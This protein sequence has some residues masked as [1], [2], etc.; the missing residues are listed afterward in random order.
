MTAPERIWKCASCGLQMPGT[1]QCV[2]DVAVSWEP[3][4]CCVLKNELRLETETENI[5]RDMAEGRFPGRS[6]P[7]VV[8]ATP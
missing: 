4:F 7:M 6:D 2:T 1:C 8:R 3:E 5:A